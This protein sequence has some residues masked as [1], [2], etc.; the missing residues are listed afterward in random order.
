MIGDRVHDIEAAQKNGLR[1]VGV[2]WGYGTEEELRAARP[3]F[4]VDSM[5]EVQALVRTHEGQARKKGS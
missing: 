1:A 2:R 3:D 5:S 4:L